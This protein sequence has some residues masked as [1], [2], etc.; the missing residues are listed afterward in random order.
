M[1]RP[2][3]GQGFFHASLEGRIWYTIVFDYIDEERE[4][5]RLLARGGRAV[6]EEEERLRSN[7]QKLM[8]E[9]EVVINGERV[10]AVVERAFIELRGSPVRAS[11]TFITR[12]DY[13]PLPGRNV[14]EDFYEETRAE[15]DYTVT[16]A[17]P[18]CVR[19]LRVESPGD[20]DV[21]GSMVRIRVR[22][23]TRIPGYESIVFD[24][25]GCR[26]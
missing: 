19:V 6:R 5:A 12:M 18:P 16:W 26:G 4:Y 13:K 8:D 17:F 11:V 23:G 9:E 21:E 14:Y 25:S 2:V 1:V 10:R 20:V 22:R 24:A 7:M 3:Y 15:Y